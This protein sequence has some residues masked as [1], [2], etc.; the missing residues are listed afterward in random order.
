RTTLAYPATAVSVAKNLAAN[1][2][3][4]FTYPDTSSPCVAV[5]L[6]AP[7]PGGVG[8]DDDIV[9]YSV[10]CTHMGCPTSYDSSSKTFSCPCHFTEFDAEKAG[11]MI[12]GEATADLPRV[13]LRY[14]AASDA[15]TA[16][17]VDGLIYGRQ[18]NVI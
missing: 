18:A 13:L 6:G 3:S 12:C 9:A 4:S 10:L 2:P 16:V 17:G 15:L 1:E 14:D 7:V 8:P 11:Q 5:K